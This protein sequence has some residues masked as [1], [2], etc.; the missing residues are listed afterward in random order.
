MRPVGVSK[1]LV[2]E[3]YLRYHA[4][5]ERSCHDADGTLGIIGAAGMAGDAGFCRLATPN[6]SLKTSLFLDIFLQ[7]LFRHTLL[8][9]SCSWKPTPLSR[10]LELTYTA[11]GSL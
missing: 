3:R 9:F 7:P 11:P 8:V 1:Y 10:L 4:V 6:L 2:Q 5:H